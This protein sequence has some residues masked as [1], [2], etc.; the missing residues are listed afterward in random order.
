M[1]EQGESMEQTKQMSRL[2]VQLARLD[3]RFKSLDSLPRQVSE[4]EKKIDEV[5]KYLS[6]EYV[7]KDDL[8][9]ILSERK[10]AFLSTQGVLIGI[11]NIVVAALVAYGIG[12]M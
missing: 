11:I 2:E 9:R 7:R 3:E 10:S 6:S 4:I 5:T 12:K 8:D 1:H